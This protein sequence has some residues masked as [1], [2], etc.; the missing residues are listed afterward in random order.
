MTLPEAT[1]LF[2]R[3]AIDAGTDA[4]ARANFQLLVTDLVMVAF[5]DA[6][7]VEGAGGRDWGI[8]TVVGELAG[9]EVR[10]WQ[11]KFVLKWQDKGPRSQVY[12]SYASAK[13]QADKNAYTLK[14]WTLV[15]PCILAPTELQWF[16]KWAKSKLTADGVAV[17]LWDGTR[18]R[19]LLQ[20]IDAAHIAQQA[21]P[22]LFPVASPPVKAKVTHLEDPAVFA[23]A[24]FV[25]QLHE[26]GRT[27]T[28]AASANFFATDALVRD[29]AEKGDEMSLAAIR[30][31]ELE[32]R[33]I[34]ENQFSKQAPYADGHGRITNLI[35]EVLQG[36]SECEDPDGI[37]LNKAHKRGT[38]HRIVEHQWAGW[39]T[40][41]RKI[42]E[43]HV[44]PSAASHGSGRADEAAATVNP[45]AHDESGNHATKIG[46]AMKTTLSVDE[47]ENA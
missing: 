11:S 21:F 15:V 28:D 4:A 31:L 25:R 32:V 29:L 9:G 7:T 3:F 16:Q 27:E 10:L 24:L 18:L 1:K 33:T 6:T 42:A 37:A 44:A 43:Q 30:D 34:W 35:D 14:S 13:K 26:A 23:G 45:E 2:Q 17:T 38:A 47:V 8:D 22:H 39:V 41:W 5:P 46:S 12:S 40:H 20:S 19:H 36:A